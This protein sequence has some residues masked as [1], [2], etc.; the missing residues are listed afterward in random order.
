MAKRKLYDEMGNEV[1]GARIKKPFYKRIWFWLVLLFIVPAA[2]Q[3]GGDSESET[4]PADTAENVTNETEVAADATEAVSEEEASVEEEREEEPEQTLEEAYQAILDTYTIRLKEEAPALVDAYN[5]EYPDNQNGLEGL[6]ELSNEKIS[7]L[8]E[9]ANEGVSEMADLYY[10]KG[11]GSYETY[12]EW[13][14]KVMDVY[15]TEAEQITNAYMD[16]AQ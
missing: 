5:A 6:A 2:L 14:G 9:T 15:M 10:S 7:Q 13:A 8:A 3:M 16:S 1:K 4:P 12:E 11:S